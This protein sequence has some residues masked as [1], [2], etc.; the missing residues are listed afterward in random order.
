MNRDYKDKQDFLQKLSESYEQIQEINS[1]G[2]GIIYSGIHRRLK[3]K[4]ILKKIRTDRINLIG[5]E[6]EKQILMNFLKVGPLKFL[7]L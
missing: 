3:Q 4:V 7:R 2:G 6:R 1:G 5:S